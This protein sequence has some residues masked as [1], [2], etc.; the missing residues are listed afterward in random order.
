MET[1]VLDR[2]INVLCVTAK[3]FPDGIMDAHERLRELVPSYQQRNYFGISRPEGHG[4]IQYH[5]AIE[6]S[7]P[8]EGTSLGCKTIILKKGNYHYLT[9]TDYMNNLP[10][11]GPA[12]EKILDTKAV[13]PQGYCVEWYDFGKDEVKCM[14]R[15]NQ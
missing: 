3:S 11:I 6:E 15:M 5:A 7:F 10:K 8:G 4:V 12:F 9:V 2:D 13:D 1:F 14:V